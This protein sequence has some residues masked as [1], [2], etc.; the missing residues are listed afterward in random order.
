MSRLNLNIF[1]HDWLHPV[2]II[3]AILYSLFEYLIMGDSDHA[4]LK[5]KWTMPESHTCICPQTTCS[6]KPVLSY[7]NDLM[8]LG[9]ELREQSTNMTYRQRVLFWQFRLS[10]IGER[11]GIT[12]VIP[13]G[14]ATVLYEN[15]TKVLS[16]Q[17]VPIKS[18]RV[19]LWK[20]NVVESL[21]PVIL[22]QKKH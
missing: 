14:D 4:Y 2:A 10:S 20:F 11:N 15:L 13:S 21:F 16:L 19:C 3:G 22:K 7:Y 18:E 17:L 8:G 12:S 9:S 5:S 6:I 1:R